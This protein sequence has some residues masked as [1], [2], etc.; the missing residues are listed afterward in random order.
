[1]I[2]GVRVSPLKQIP[3]ERG[4]VLHML[5]ADAEHFEA[6]GEVYFSCVWPGAIKSRS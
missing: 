3:D 6:F 1:M 5:R 4:K 2:A